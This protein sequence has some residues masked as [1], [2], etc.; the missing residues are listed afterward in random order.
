M[1][2]SFDILLIYR[3]YCG[4]FVSPFT[5]WFKFKFFWVSFCCGAVLELILDE[6]LLFVTV[7]CF[8]AGE[9]SLLFSLGEKELSCFR[10]RIYSINC[11]K[12]RFL[13]W[14]ISVGCACLKGKWICSTCL[15]F[16]PWCS[17]YV[18]SSVLIIWNLDSVPDIMTR[19]VSNKWE[20]GGPDD[21]SQRTRDLREALSQLWRLVE[22]KLCTR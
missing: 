4:N 6:F 1:D 19:A 10:W 14:E 16:P 12:T 8:S 21:E 22:S 17:A 15:F 13:L 18:Y 9:I 5:C 2:A 11:V 20:H 7:D 3:Q